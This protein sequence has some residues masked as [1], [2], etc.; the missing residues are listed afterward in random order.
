MTKRIVVVIGVLVAAGL[1]YV[2]L[3]G[4]FPPKAD[5][6]G[7]VGGAKRYHAEQITNKDVVLQDPEVQAFIQSDLFHQMTTNPDFRKAVQKEEFTK[8]VQDNE[9][10]TLIGTELFKKVS[11]TEAYQTVA[12]NEGYQKLVSFLEKRRESAAEAAKTGVA[13]DVGRHYNVALPLDPVDLL[14]IASE[15]QYKN[16]GQTESFK[17]LVATGLLSRLMEQTNYLK[18]ASGMIAMRTSDAERHAVDKDASR[19]AVETG[20]RPTEYD[21]RKTPVELGKKDAEL[22]ASKRITQETL[23]HFFGTLE[24]SRLGSDALFR[25]I[26]DEAMLQRMAA[27]GD[28]AKVVLAGNE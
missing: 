13:S 21:K 12:A 16:V 28:L 20:M 23:R 15:D 11:E 25:K 24:V 1:G 14:K 10:K 6:E 27:S 5:L 3:R 26:V 18:V 22:D 19:H 2:S 7:T 4:W 8:L 17:K 9:F